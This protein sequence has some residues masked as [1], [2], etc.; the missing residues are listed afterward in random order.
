MATE[1]RLPEFNQINARVGRIRPYQDLWVL[2]TMGGKD[3]KVR[4]QSEKISTIR[5]MHFFGVTSG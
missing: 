2:K 5:N 3:L 1:N 4:S